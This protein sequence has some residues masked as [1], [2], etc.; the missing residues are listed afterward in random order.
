MIGSIRNR[1]SPTSAAATS[2]DAATQ[3]GVR[4]RGVLEIGLVE[5]GAAP[6]R[7]LPSVHYEANLSP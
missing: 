3:V 7:R 4:E 6:L 2:I 5:V 1:L